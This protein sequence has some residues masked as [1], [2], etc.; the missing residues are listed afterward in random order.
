M[1]ARIRVSTGG[2]PIEVNDNGDTIELRTD[3]DFM[4]EC[5]TIQRNFRVSAEKYEALLNDENAE[6]EA[7]SAAIDEVFKTTD[8]SIDKL[9]GE[10]ACTKI[11]P[12]R[13]G[14]MLYTEF[15]TQLSKIMSEQQEAAADKYLV[16]REQRRGARK[17]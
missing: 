15:F 17:K 2:I 12:P 11:F 5:L 16:S 8:S 7:V 6:P 10:G 1:S 9:F 13:R 3:A 14:V 4:K